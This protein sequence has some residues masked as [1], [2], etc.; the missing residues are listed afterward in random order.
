MASLAALQL[1]V[2][3]LPVAS[4]NVCTCNH[5]TATVANGVN[6]TLC[7]SDGQEDCSA[8][9]AGFYL[10]ASTGTTYQYIGPGICLTRNG[11]HR[12]FQKLVIVL[13]RFRRDTKVAELYAIY[14]ARLDLI[15]YSKVR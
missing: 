6:E 13:Y 7:D 1:L 11:R 14:V 3:L 15:A 8:C 5:G 12:Y 10:S 9:N 4:A 2:L